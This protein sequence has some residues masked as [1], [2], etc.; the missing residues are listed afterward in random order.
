[1]ATF[2]AWVKLGW[3]EAGETPTPVV[4]RSEMERGLPRQ[5]RT[6]ADSLVSVPVTAY[7]DTAAESL[8]FESWFFGDA[9][10]GA[11]WFNFTLPR[12]GQVVQARV[13]G[14][15]IGTLKPTNKTWAYSERS[16][17]LEYVRQGFV[18]LPPGLHAVAPERVMSVQRNSVA[19]YVDAGGVLRTA[20]ANV[21]RYTYA[22]FRT[23]LVA[24][25]QNLAGTAWSGANAVTAS[26]VF[27][28]GAPFWTVTKTFGTASEFQANY[29][30]AVYPGDVLTASV[31]LLAGSATVADLGIYE[32]N[33]GAW[34]PEGDFSVLEGPG[35]LSFYF[36]SAVRV[37]GLSAT[38][39][40]VVRVT[41]SGFAG[42]P[43]SPAFLLYPGGADSTTL[44]HSV[45]ATRVQV[46]RGPV[47][48]A[49]IP[50]DL[51]PVT[52]SDGVSRLLVES[53]GANLISAPESFDAGAWVKQNSTVAPGVLDPAPNGVQFVADA[54]Q[55][56]AAN[57]GKNLYTNA[58]GNGRSFSVFAKPA[59]VRYLG[60]WAFVGGVLTGRT[61][62]LVAG[63]QGAV[64]PGS[65]SLVS[66]FIEPLANGYFRVGIEANTDFSVCVL[67]LRQTD[68]SGEEAYVG[69]PANS[70]YLWGAQMET[71]STTSY[72]P[73]TRAADIVTVLA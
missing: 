49:Y 35:A 9:L 53:E 7:F 34:G 29:F 60:L 50:T 14:G 18:T 25:S 11:D 47:A 63:T 23:N 24:N 54:V 73:I 72:M 31:A 41:R 51:A 16:F 55:E 59:G 15:D 10:A 21:A 33:A 28:Q 27:Y 58:V 68:S 1:M 57:V 48:T 44:G 71:G 62:D 46:E 61:F 40:T 22:G 70:V 5:R 12:T 26:G 39:P 8:A 56:V 43:G 13:V 3:R 32:F 67:Q 65:G 36:G 45:R 30:G 37:T 38:V 42:A 52:V 19:T 2:P 69:N 17:Q 4:A 6:A 66:S 20:A 64:W